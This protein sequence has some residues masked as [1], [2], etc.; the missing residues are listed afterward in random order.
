MLG[1]ASQDSGTDSDVVILVLHSKWAEIAEV[2]GKI[3]LYGNKAID[4]MTSACVNTVARSL[5]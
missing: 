4:V 3:W 1:R 2:L 5:L